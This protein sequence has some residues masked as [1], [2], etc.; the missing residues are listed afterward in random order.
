MRAGRDDLRG[1]RGIQGVR[2]VQRHPGHHVAVAAQQLGGDRA[3]LGDHGERAQHVVVDD[4]AH[5]LPPALQRQ[6]VQLVAEPGPAVQLEHGPVGGRGPVEGD[7]LPDAAAGRLE[8]LLGWPVTTNGEPTTSSPLEAAVP[9]QRGH[10]DLAQVPLG[11]E[12]VAQ[13]PVGH[14]AGHRRHRLAHP[15][16][17]H[18]GCA[19]RVG[20][21]V[22]ERRHQRVL[23]EL[24]AEL[25]LGAVVPAAPDRLQRQDE[26]AHPRWPD[27]TRAWRSVALYAVGF[28]SRGRAKAALGRAAERR[29]P[30]RARTSGCARTPPRSRCRARWCRWRPPPG[31]ARRTDRA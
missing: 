11:G 26:L 19:V 28:A 23:V 7:L 2:R 30:A 27:A 18:P 24:A 20:P 1:D 25:Q 22:E 14:L 9:G 12:A 8:F 17:Q 3:G 6:L 10:G 21:R 15:G 13:E 29:W 16:Q 5:V 4:R 31:R